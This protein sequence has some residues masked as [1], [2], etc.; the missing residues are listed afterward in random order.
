MAG[1]LNKEHFADQ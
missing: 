1:E